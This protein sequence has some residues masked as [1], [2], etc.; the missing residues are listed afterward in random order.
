M[1]VMKH[2]PDIN[3]GV[4]EPLFL[5]EYETPEQYQTITSSEVNSWTT[6]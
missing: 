3:V 4:T 6:F 5:W 1:F 2:D